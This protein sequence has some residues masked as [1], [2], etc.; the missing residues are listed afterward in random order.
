MKSIE[1]RRLDTRAVVTVV[2][3]Q[4]IAMGHH[5]ARRGTGLIRLF[6]LKWNVSA[7]DTISHSSPQQY[8]RVEQ[9]VHGV[10]DIREFVQLPLPLPRIADVVP[11]RAGVVP[12]SG[13]DF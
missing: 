4:R 6:R 11:A 2:H 7:T 10:C 5:H 3:H 8:Q 9:V 1:R 13:W 12:R